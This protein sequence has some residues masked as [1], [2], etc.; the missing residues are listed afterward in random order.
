MT[1]TIFWN[2]KNYA[3][4]FIKSVKAEGSEEL[5]GS[6]KIYVS[7]TASRAFLVDDFNKVIAQRIVF[8]SYE[9]DA[10]LD[11]EDKHHEKEINKLCNYFAEIIWDE[12]W[13]EVTFH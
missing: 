9:L 2:G 6:F 11:D 7:R 10:I 4:E 3:C 1:S 5:K 12:T 13:D 8:F